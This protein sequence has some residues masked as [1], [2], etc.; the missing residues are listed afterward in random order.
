ML[1]R[2]NCVGT[3]IRAVWSVKKA[4]LVENYFPTNNGLPLKNSSVVCLS[5]SATA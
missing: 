5:A 4:K 2:P 3:A 1:N